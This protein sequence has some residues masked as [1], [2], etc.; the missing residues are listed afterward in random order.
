LLVNIVDSGVRAS[1]IQLRQ[2]LLA[3]GYIE[4]APGKLVFIEDNYLDGLSLQS[5]VN[6]EKELE[7]QPMIKQFQH[8]N[9][10]I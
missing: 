5:L 9:P 3:R 2:M 8:L 6:L 4:T 7:K 10:A 1:D